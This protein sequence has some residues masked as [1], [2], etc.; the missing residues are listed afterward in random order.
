[1]RKAIGTV[2]VALVAVSLLAGQENA[3]KPTAIIETSA[4]D[5]TCE[6]F[7]DKAPRTVRNF[8]GLATGTRPWRNPKTKQIEHNKP[9]YNGTLFHRAVPGL[10][11][12]GGDPTGTGNGGPGYVFDDEISDLK[13]DQAGILAMANKGPNSNG[14]QFFITE[15]AQP[16]LNRRHTIFGQCNNT[17]LVSEITGRP[18]NS[19][20]DRPRLPVVIQRI[21]IKN[22]T[23]PAPATA[24]ATPTPAATTQP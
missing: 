1:M 12:Q 8:V 6:L 15:D 2:V 10:M 24:A 19:L 3:P 21:V 5:F 4:G 16:H 23:P 7:S 13:F 22:Y 14:S 9:L 18:R 17:R 11:I 20:N